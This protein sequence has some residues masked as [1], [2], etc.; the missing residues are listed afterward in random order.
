MRSPLAALNL[1]ASGGML[2]ARQMAADNENR[3]RAADPFYDVRKRWPEFQHLDF[4][5]EAELIKQ[6]KSKWGARDRAYILR[7]VDRANQLAEARR[8]LKSQEGPHAR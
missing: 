7:M 6:K 3:D 4:F 8:I 2:E 1:L 5:A